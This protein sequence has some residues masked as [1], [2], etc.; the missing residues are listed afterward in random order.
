M[1]HVQAYLETHGILTYRARHIIGN[2]AALRGMS[3]LQV[4][5]ANQEDRF[6]KDPA[7]IQLGVCC[8]ESERGGYAPNSHVR[9]H[10]LSL[11]KQI[12][13]RKGIKS[14]EDYMRIAGTWP[15]FLL[16]HYRNLVDPQPRDT[17]LT[18]RALMRG[19]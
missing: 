7:H 19:L 13:K 3:D 17:T 8:S 10:L 12:E 9:D 14:E 15:I 16:P 18:A 1:D 6:L 11:R 5:L 4:T 2:I